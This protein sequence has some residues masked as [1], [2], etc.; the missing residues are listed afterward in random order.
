MAPN[1]EYLE[2]VL[3]LLAPLG[4][5]SSKAMFGGFGLFHN[6]NMFALISGTA[7]FFKVD[8]SNRPRYE[9]AGSKQYKPMPYYQVPEKLFQ[10]PARLMEW[11]RESV[12]IAHAS[13][14]AKKRQR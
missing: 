8:D 11:A 12:S 4:G 9:E 1:K 2:S 5:V 3:K 7:L 6:G 10:D 14:G 13:T